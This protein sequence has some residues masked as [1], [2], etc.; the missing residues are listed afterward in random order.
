M[1]SNKT[2][3]PGMA[4]QG[5]GMPQPQG[6]VPNNPMASQGNVPAGTVFPGMNMD[7]AQAGEAEENHKP[8][9]GFLFSVSRNAAGEYW[10][11]YLGPNSIG[12]AMGSNIVLAEQTVSDIHC[13]IIAQELKNPDRLFVYIQESGSTCGTMVNGSSLDFNPR[14]IKSGDII[15]VGEHY[16]LYVLLVDVRQLGLSQVENFLP[17]QIQNP[18]PAPIGTGGFIPQP[19]MPGANPTMPFGG[20]Q[21]GQ[22]Q[23]SS[24]KP[25]PGTV[26]DSGQNW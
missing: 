17:V 13:K 2:V 4:P 11:I 20:F 7:S 14:E 9:L 25:Y 10:P 15:T 23:P 12:R 18:N 21:P 8:I 1:S 6:F 16:E 19:G 24:P 26:V 5:A 22:P 3:V